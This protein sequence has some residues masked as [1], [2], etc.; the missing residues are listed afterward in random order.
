MRWVILA[1]IVSLA[2]CASLTESGL[3]PQESMYSL[4]GRMRITAE[5]EILRVDFRFVKSPES[6]YFKFWGPFGVRLGEALVSG[7]HVEFIKPNGE[8]LV[9][10]S[11]ELDRMILGSSVLVAIDFGNWLRLQPEGLAYPK[12]LES[13]QHLDTTVRVTQ[14]QSVNG[15]LVCKRLDISKTNL[16]IVVLCDRWVFSNL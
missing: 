10:G 1:A 16:K 14:H 8:R 7:E 9:L 13:W 12:S 15:E 11:D 2:G 6:S 4:T 3:P 5:K